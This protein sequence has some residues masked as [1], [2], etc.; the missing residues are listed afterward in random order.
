[1]ARYG[2][3]VAGVFVALLAFTGCKPAASEPAAQGAAPPTTPS[4]GSSGAATPP[5]PSAPVPPA[6]HLTVLQSIDFSKIPV[7]ENTSRNSH[8]PTNASFSLAKSDQV[9]VPALAEN[10]A[11]AL[12][13][14]GWKPAPQA[15]GTTWTDESGAA[16]YEKSGIHLLATI[17]TSV[18][19]QPGTKD[20]NAGLF[21][22]GN[23]DVR[24]LPHFQG[25]VIGTPTFETLQ[26]STTEKIATVRDHHRQAYEKLGWHQYR[27]PDPEGVEIPVET[28]EL[29]QSFV[30][31]GTIVQY[32]YR[33]DDAQLIALCRSSLLEWDPPIPPQAKSVEL[34]NSPPFVFCYTPLSVEDVSQFYQKSLTPL[35]WAGESIPSPEGKKGTRYQ[36]SAP[37]K[38]SM[39]LECLPSGK[40]TLVQFSVTQ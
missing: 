22:L 35:G 13:G 25:T 27:E 17:G 39:T 28:K 7:P 32:F 18:G 37:G 33:M 30:Q 36:F 11:K 26:F 20:V 1:M 31:N 6:A 23:V 10:F 16:Y 3:P 19:F 8:S 12:A 24:N 14:Q 2:N 38:K 29:Q 4:T 40:S 9:R 21:L 34:R 5:A 15:G